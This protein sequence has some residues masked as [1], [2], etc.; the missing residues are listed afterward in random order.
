MPR[1]SARGRRRNLKIAHGDVIE[2]RYRGRSVQAP[3]WVLPGHAD[4]CV[5]VHL[6]Y[7]RER[8]GSVGNALGFN[9]GKLQTSDAP[10]GGAGLEIRQT[11]RRHIFATTQEHQQM[12][13]RDLI[14]VQSAG[15]ENH[16][17]VAAPRDDE[18]LYPPV[19]YE[20]PAWGMVIDLTA[21]I[22]CSACTIACQAENNIPVVGREQV[23]RRRE[24]HWI[25]VDRYFEG[26]RGKPANAAPAGAVHALRECAVRVGLSGR[27]HGA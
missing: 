20:R 19:K 14:R 4:G 13:G 3:A 12:E 25:R 2:L 21:C 24:M 10:W 5:T 17:S 15:E 11:D 9:A 16:A 6:G 1:I 23:L 7:G 26:E 22:G 8:A 18:S 27:G